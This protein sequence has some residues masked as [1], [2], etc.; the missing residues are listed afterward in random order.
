MNQPDRHRPEARSGQNTK[1]WSQ[2]VRELHELYCHWTDQT[3]T[4]RFDR[5]RLWYEF[6]RAGFSA[7]DLKRVVTYL[8]KEIR[9][10]RRNVGALKLS[11]LLQLDRF[12][13]D[14]NIS[15]VRLNPRPL[16]PIRLSSQRLIQKSTI[17]N[18]T[19]YSTNSE[20]WRID[21]HVQPACWVTINASSIDHRTSH[22]KRSATTAASC[23]VRS[24]QYSNVTP[25]ANSESWRAW[26]SRARK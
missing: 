22:L 6:L 20:S 3:L 14:L 12:E 18:A 19:R 9:A 10:E 16:L 13:E 25:K 7:A 1:S 11:N 24:P 2:S 4:L 8:Q 5:E 17:S 15:R 26:V 23:M 21:V